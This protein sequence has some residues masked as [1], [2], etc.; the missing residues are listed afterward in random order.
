MQRTAQTEEADVS[1]RLSSGAGQL[2]LSI[3][4]AQTARLVAYLACLERWNKVYNLSAWKRPAD[5]VAHHLLDSMTL[6][7]PLRGYAAGRRLRVLD[8]GSGA[9]F[10]AAVLAIMNPDWTIT[11][12]DAVSKKMAFVQQAAAETGIG[13]L[14]VR[15]GRLEDL[16]SSD[17]SDL[18]VSRAFASL[19]RFVA[20]TKHLVAPGGVWVA[21]KGRLP[22]TEMAE[23]SGGI[24]VFHVEPVTVPGLAAERHLVWMRRIQA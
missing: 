1:Q 7:G 17:S 16:G 14:R 10:P 13:N 6:V 23:L 19:D 4:G 8:A 3:D 12:V 11:A 24:E 2:G 21:Q 18:V 15:H 9:G 5:L 20:V 22:K